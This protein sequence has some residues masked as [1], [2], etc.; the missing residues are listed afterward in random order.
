M[1]NSEACW[2]A[3]QL[4]AAEAQIEEQKKQWELRRVASLTGV[5]DERNNGLETLSNC[6][7]AEAVA[8]LTYSHQDSVNQVKKKSGRSRTQSN[9]SQSQSSSSFQSQPDGSVSSQR[10]ERKTKKRHS[11]ALVANNSHSLPCTDSSK[12]SKDSN[13]ASEVV[14][15]SP[16]PGRE[17]RK[18]TRNSATREQ[19]RDGSVTPEVPLDGSSPPVSATNAH[20]PRTRSRGT[21]NINLWTLDRHPLLPGAKISPCPTKTL[22]TNKAKVGL[23]PATTPNPNPN[24]HPNLNPSVAAHSVDGNLSNGCDPENVPVKKVKLIATAAA[25]DLETESDLDVVS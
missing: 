8:L 24:P 15:R 12:E 17:Q 13:D 4:K 23:A 18:R 11:V 19:Q 21:V 14:N 10:T 6:A 3:E 2:S 20:S 1:E 5:D 7:D 9:L 22:S 25:A 16:T